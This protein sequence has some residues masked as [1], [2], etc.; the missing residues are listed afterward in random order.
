[1]LLRGHTAPIQSLALSRDATRILSCGHDNTARLWDT[2]THKLLWTYISVHPTLAF[3]WV[4]FDT[5]GY[6]YAL[7]ASGSEVRLWD[8]RSVVSGVSVRV[9]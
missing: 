5:W 3:Q 7:S 1:M 4:R 6:T 2:K 8:L 9:C